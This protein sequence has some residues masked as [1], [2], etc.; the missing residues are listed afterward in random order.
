MIE[1]NSGGQRVCRTDRR[2]SP[3]VVGTIAGVAIA[4]VVL[5]HAFR[6]NQTDF[7]DAAT[8]GAETTSVFGRVDDSQIHCGDG[9]DADLCIAGAMHKENSTAV[10]LGN[11]Q[12]HAINQFR[13]GDVNGPIILHE[14]L[15]PAHLSVVAFSQPNANLQEHWVLFEYLGQRLPIKVLILPV[16]FDDT[17][18][19][20]LRP[21]IAKLLSDPEVHRILSARDLGRKIISSNAQVIKDPQDGDTAGIQDTLQEKVER[22]LT[23]WLEEHS[24]LWQARPEM[25]GRLMNG[26]YAFR[27][28]VFGITPST[29]RNSIRGRY[30]DNLA[31]L[32]AILESAARRRISAVVYVA[33][34]RQDVEL[35]Y[36][37]TEYRAFKVKVQD[38]ATQ[39]GAAYSN[40]EKLV[41]S[42]FWG[43]KDATSAGGA[44]EIDFMHFQASGHK[45][46]AERMSQLVLRAVQANGDKQK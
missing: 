2:T 33:P 21:G 39:T 1:R 29:K 8:F 31:A 13:A 5:T 11:S 12:L 44:P 15:K 6:A 43:K 3:A 16:V 23:K 22:Q 45:L 19:S 25:R 36:V 28:T 37:D 17:R 42:E 18:E 46:L 7:E 4:L 24:E 26:L 27:N 40:L 9:R 20:G 30:D 41:P 35:P 34:I 38:L 32:R 14:R 10:W